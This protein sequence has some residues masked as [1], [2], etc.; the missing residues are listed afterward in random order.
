MKRFM[1][2]YGSVY[3]PSGGM[4]DFVG[5]FDS[6]EE[7]LEAINRKNAEDSTYDTDEVRW[8]YVWAHIYDTESRAEVWSR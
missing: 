1:A 2:F 5:D 3:Y 6:M 4:D 8:R 7:A